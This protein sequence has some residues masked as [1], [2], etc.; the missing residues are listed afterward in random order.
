MQNFHYQK[1]TRRGLFHCLKIKSHKEARRAL[2]SSLS[3][4]VILHGAPQTKVIPLKEVNNLR[5]KYHAVP[6]GKTVHVRGVETVVNCEICRCVFADRLWSPENCIVRF[7]K[8]HKRKRKGK[9]E[10]TGNERNMTVEEKLE[11]Y[12]LT[13]QELNDLISQEIKQ[14]S[15]SSNP[16]EHENNEDA[17]KEINGNE[18]DVKSKAIQ[19]RKERQAALKMKMQDPRL[20]KVNEKKYRQYSYKILLWPDEFE[21]AIKT[22]LKNGDPK[23]KDVSEFA[24]ESDEFF[25]SFSDNYYP[26]NEKEYKDLRYEITKSTAALSTAHVKLQRLLKE[27]QE[28]LSELRDKEK[29]LLE[30]SRAIVLDWKS[31]LAQGKKI[32]K[33]KT[34]MKRGRPRK[35][36]VKE[37][38]IERRRRKRLEK[39]QKVRREAAER[40]KSQNLDDSK[41][42]ESEIG[43]SQDRVL[44]QVEHDLVDHDHQEEDIPM[45]EE[46]QHEADDFQF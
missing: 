4:E 27:T 5:S 28:K 8:N 37:D 6:C 23:W 10:E 15:I 21:D 34:G 18:K 14:K 25:K 7:E 46:S 24:A 19:K 30:N 39:L 9:E 36:Q 17:S 43:Q 32:K 16:T 3:Q 11:K 40:E 45:D 42:N 13:V 2:E 1:Y 29:K 38:P 26:E 20:A 33:V 12:G 22:C 41:L 35:G 44:D 31:F